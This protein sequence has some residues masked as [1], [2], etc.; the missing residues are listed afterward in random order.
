[1]IWHHRLIPVLSVSLLT[2]AIPAAEAFCA[3]GRERCRCVSPAPAQS[4]AAFTR[5][6]YDRA[7]AVFQATVVRID[8]L[9][10]TTMRVNGESWTAERWAARLVVTATWKGVRTDT[11]TVML[12]RDSSCELWLTPDTM[13]L[14][15][16]RVGRDGTFFTGKCTGTVELHAAGEALAALGSGQMPAPRP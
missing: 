9:G 6:R 14:I 8:S 2:S 7:D 1:M 5:A 13:Y 4:N 3:P 16:A 10:P 12:N 15:F 11:T